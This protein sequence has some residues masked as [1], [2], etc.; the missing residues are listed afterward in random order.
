MIPCRP[1]KA[2]IW[3]NC[4]AHPLFASEVPE[5]PPSDPA[6]EGTCAAW[7]AECVLRGDAHSCIDLVDRIHD[8]GWIVTYEMAYIVQQYVDHV[9]SHIAETGGHIST[10]QFVVICEYIKGTFDSSTLTF[11]GDTMVIDD[12]KY[13]FDIV[14]V[15]EN[16]QVILYGA[17]EYLRLGKP[18]H[19]KKVQLGIYQP[20]AFHHLGVYRT[21]TMGIDELM[22][23]AQDL[24][25]KGALCQQP[26]PVATPGNHCRRCEAATICEALAHSIYKLSGQ[27]I[28][29]QHRRELSKSELENEMSV[30]DML[31]KLIK[32]RYNALQPIAE[33]H[34][35]R[36]G[37]RGFYMKPRAGHRKFKE[38]AT[39]FVIKA[40]TGVNPVK[41]ELISP[42]DLE[43]EGVPANIVKSL[44]YTP[45]L[46]S[47]FTRMSDTAMGEMFRKDNK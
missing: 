43:K 1:S 31:Q 38:H 34:L 29:S 20:R 19:I 12:L 7:V 26:N 3:S 30:L 37:F 44:A 35:K 32:A 14:E 28:E 13:G 9:R 36:E 11:F 21:W 5:T 45:S 39:P 24:V 41:E 23:R 2:Y 17:G 22:E 6:R 40:L 15:F 33:H 4:A 46:P 8:N 47:A 18:S 42:A 27:V 10:E 16:P 25:N